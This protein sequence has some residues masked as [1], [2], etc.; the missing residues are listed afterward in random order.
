MS[1][2]RGAMPEV[3]KLPFRWVPGQGPD[4]AALGRMIEMFAKPEKPMGEAWFIA[5]ERKMYPELLGNLELLA[6]EDILDPLRETIG[7]SCFGPHNEWTEW[8]HYLLPRLLRRDWGETG[9]DPIELIISAFMAQHPDSSGEMPYSEFTNDALLTIGQYIMAPRC[10]PRG[11]LHA[12]RC[13][14]KSQRVDGTFGWYEADG[15][16]SASI[17]FCLKYLPSKQVGPWLASVL[18]IPNAYWKAQLVVWLIGAHPL[19]TGVIDQPGQLPESGPAHV[20]WDASYALAGNYTGDFNLPVPL[21][22][23]I[24]DANKSSALETILGLDL[25]EFLLE[26]QTNPSLQELAAET[27]GLPDRFIKLYAGVA[28]TL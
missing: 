23:F 12:T 18:S 19:L 10:W 7:P 17:F 4:P 3:S 26:W 13:L 25:T 14:N 2:I 9:C 1:I 8:F 16:L 20:G 22:P 27:T 28:P 11:V 5:P 24:P 21:T 15:P 6:D